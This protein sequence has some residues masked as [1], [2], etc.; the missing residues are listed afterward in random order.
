MKQLQLIAILILSLTFAS[1]EAQTTRILFVFDASNSMNG[2]WES[3]R[4]INTATSLL[5]QSLEELYG[6]E[7][8]EL[9]LRVYGHQTV[10][11]PGQQDCDDTQLVVPI[12]SGNNLVIK[13]ELSRITPKGTTPIARS[14]EK[15]AG[16][17]TDCEDCRNII[18]LI[19]DGI[20]ACDEDPCAVSR[21][22]QEKN[23][24]VKPFVIGIGL[25]EKYKSTFE[26]VGNYFDATNKETFETVLDIVITQAL[27]N[28]S[29]QFNL[30]DDQNEP[31]ETNV[32][33]SLY[34]Q[35]TGEN[36][37][38]FVHTLNKVGNPDT[39]SLDP[40]PT[41]RAVVHTIP[42]IEVTDL[43]VTPG[44][45]TEFDIPAAQGFLKFEFSGRSEYESLQC[46]VRRDCDVVHHQPFD[47]KQRYLAGSYDL[48]I[49]TTPR[50]HL[51]NVEIKPNDETRIAIPSPGRLML[52]TGTMGFGGIYLIEKNELIQAIKFD[53]GDPSGRY[54]LQPGKYK[55]IFRSRSS[56][57]TLY[58][59]EKE[60]TISSGSNTTINLN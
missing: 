34:D 11:I 7:N 27:N 37:Y 49:L 20:E 16:D 3:E 29:V 24:I 57:Q 60:F 59:I 25:D 42:T 30:M 2:Y 44:Q 55:L 13:K 28:T 23:I 12:S 33:I 51:D 53:E 8:L 6:I 19:T 56:N 54:I 4:K 45:H 31:K 22:L 58:T 15:A 36:L 35:N 18:I 38:N 47:S 39:L 32:G 1:A 40:L 9:G 50:I 14:L 43:R 46:I 41:Y 52:N 5:S 21:A 10:H 48:E 26:C 17:F